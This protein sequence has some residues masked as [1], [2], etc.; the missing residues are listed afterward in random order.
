MRVLV[1]GAAGQLGREIAASAPESTEVS[2]LKREQLDVTEPDAVARAF[3]DLR[4]ELVINTAAYTAVDRAEVE[5]E[6][7]FAVNR[8]GARLL[9]EAAVRGEARLI[10][11]S[12]DF[13]FDGRQERPYAPEDPTGPL[14]VYGASK[15]EGER[16]VLSVAGGRALVLRTAWLY[17]WFG[18]NFVTAMLEKMRGSTQVVVV[19]DQEGTPT[20]A[21][22]LARA[23][24]QVA[25]LPALSGVL[26]WSDEGVVSRYA[27]A[28]AIH[29]E[30]ISAGL[31]GRPIQI[32]P[33]RTAQYPGQALR[34]AYS[35]LDS[36]ATWKLLSAKPIPWRDAL[37]SMLRERPEPGGVSHSCREAAEIEVGGEASPRSD[38]GAAAEQT[39]RKER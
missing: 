9:A 36:R 29:E 16:A 11:V 1:T 37:R 10:H 13:V 5:P 8:E 24:W 17:S 26:H 3:R 27:F 7:A 4:P 39:P 14:G 2:A 33:V 21:R 22:G 28:R 31:L 20:W 35:A 6:A 32:R 23:I 25:S 34:P 19:T 30:A 18:R 15:L 12:T 38:R